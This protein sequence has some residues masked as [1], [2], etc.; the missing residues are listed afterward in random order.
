MNGGLRVENQEP[1]TRT[2]TSGG[3]LESAT[4]SPCD[5]LSSSESNLLKRELATA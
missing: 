2:I 3:L 5:Y 1:T 4:V